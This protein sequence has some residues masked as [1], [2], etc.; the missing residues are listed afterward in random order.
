MLERVKERSVVYLGH[1]SP[2]HRL[3]PVL[4]T[5]MTIPAWVKSENAEFWMWGNMLY[6]FICRH[7]PYFSTAY[8]CLAPNENNRRHTARKGLTAEHN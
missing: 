6:C 5:E 8:S 1:S 7:P 4:K 2:R 3:A